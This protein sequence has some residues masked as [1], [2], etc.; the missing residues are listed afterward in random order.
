MPENAYLIFKRVPENRKENIMDKNKPV[1][2]LKKLLKPFAVKFF[3]W[4][5][6]FPILLSFSALQYGEDRGRT[7][8]FIK[9]LSVENAFA[10]K[11]DSL[12]EWPHEN[13]DLLPDPAIVFGRL[14]NGFRYVLAEN[15]TPRDRVSMHLDIQEGSM[16]ESDRQQGI[17]HFLEHMLFC[18]S[19]HFKPGE[20]IK[21]FQ[22]IGMQFGHDANAHTGFYETVYDVL[23]PVGDKDSLENGLLVIKDYA[24]GALLL[25]SEIDR[26]RKVILA[27]KRTR[28]SVSY[29]TFI[30][31][32]KFEFP[33]A[34]ISKRL[35]IG[36]EDVIKNADHGFLKDFYD[37][38]YRP[39]T[40]ILVMAGDF[41][42]R[43]A[44]LLIEEKFSALSSRAPPQQDPKMGDVNH[45]GIKAFYHFE[46]EAGN[47]RAGIE[48]VEKITQQPD[49]AALQKRLYIKNIADQIV[50]NRLDVLV[51]KPDAPFTSASIGSGIYFHQIEYAAIT[52]ESSPENW[53][54]SISLLEQTLRKA[55]K[56]G[57]TRSELA[58]VKKDSLSGLDNAVKRASTRNS[59][60]IA[61]E[62]MMKLSKDR[63]F[64][65]PEQKRD[66]FA[67]LI[68]S[69]TLKDVH[70]SFKDTWAPE[71]R[72][73]L[74][75]GNANL[76][77]VDAVPEDLILTAFKESGAVEVS[78]PVEP[79]LVTFPY[80]PEPEK[81]GKIINRTMLSDSGIVQV[82]FEN[83]VRLN[84]KK[85]DFK[86]N[87]ALVNISFGLGRS[88]EP[89]NMPGLATL[90]GEVV[91]ES[92]LG[93]LEKDEIKRAMAGKNTSVVFGIDE[94]SFF[95]KG[96]TVSKEISLLFQLLYAHVADP[97][98]R[99]DAY[100]LSMERFR[101]KYLKL[102]SS[103][104]GAMMLS[105]KRFL[106][107][108]DSRFG[109]P[110]FNVFKKLT[111]DHVRSWINFPLKNDKFEISVVGDFDVDSVIE[112]A[113]AYFGS[114]P[115]RSGIKIEKSSRL[116]EFPISKSVD[117]SVATQIPKGLVV[118]AYPTQD[119]WDIHRTRRF[120][121]LAN[122]FS[123]RLRERIREKSGAAYSL[124]AYNM[125]S[126]VYP[127]YG[128]FQAFV[129][130]D[131]DKSETI[132][133]E[134]KKITANLAKYGVTG[135]ELK[136]AAGPM[137]TGIKDMLRKNDYWLERVLAGS[138]KHPVQLDWNRTI[139]KD[140]ASITTDELSIL[141]KKY[142]NNEKAATIIIKPAIDK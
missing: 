137:L 127:G 130:V 78:K 114:L 123:D 18:G 30:S 119:Y 31:T 49:S 106:A 48:V 17:A 117:I 27:E 120:S 47:T 96:R 64:L 142:L 4:A 98:Y 77:D 104:D 83:G 53:K 73:V 42:A 65:S 132:I 105:G 35:P 11:I 12:P 122:V 5:V 28:D 34:K 63:V 15:H 9:Y 133:K 26:E 32:L 79:K 101:Q 25:Q 141:A 92:G 23:L 22:S 138:K 60:S 111:L 13:S 50:Q 40:M 125:P 8:Y 58:R 68:K 75:T 45:A 97:A 76:N 51:N 87:E 2:M 14:P 61:R 67:P 95:F 135:D 6:V 115:S 59:Q 128:L 124:F 36:R 41:D 108:G 112:I 110:A 139:V 80:L 21:Y 103:I 39:E 44:A 74:V 19:K 69:L 85:T 86:A 57:F 29:R 33:D 118:I 38:W 55:L 113:S 1:I 90:A 89:E 66:I 93:L 88:A 62:I 43:V 84:L 129:H 140:Y 126:R 70:D 100:A 7:G 102:S 109:L 81:K 52:A 10:G 136:R 107:G 134:V 3:I 121:V 94:E 116:P 46:K 131:P 37:T 54:K 20:L 24:D 71:H 91:N 56:Y 16:N 99:E 72:L 82:D